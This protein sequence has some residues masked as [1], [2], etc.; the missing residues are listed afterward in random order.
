MLKKMLQAITDEAAAADML[1]A[2]GMTDIRFSYVA[3]KISLAM[4]LAVG[5]TPEQLGIAQVPDVLKPT[6][7]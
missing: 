7:A 2:T 3:A 1:K 5:V 4:N 6:Q